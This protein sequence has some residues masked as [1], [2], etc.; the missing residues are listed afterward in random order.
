LSLRGREG[1]MEEERMY[2]AGGTPA[3][4]IRKVRARTLERLAT[5]TSLSFYILVLLEEQQIS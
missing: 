4:L 3:I 1:N 2:L 5:H